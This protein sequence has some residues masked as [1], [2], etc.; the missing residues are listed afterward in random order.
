MHAE[1][2]GASSAFVELVDEDGLSVGSLDKLLA[3]RDPGHLHRAFSVVLHDER[4]RV[5]LQRRADEKYHFA[6][7]WSNSC[8]GH[9]PPGSALQSAAR[10]RTFAELGVDVPLHL[11]GSFVYRATDEDSGLVEH[12]LDSVLV[13]Q[14]P[15]DTVPLLDPSEVSATRWV[16]LAALV[17]E[18]T[19]DPRAFTPWLPQV[20]ALLPARPDGTHA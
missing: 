1:Q 15:A 6:G 7:R 11:V 20:L 5:L 10:D 17:V 13:G 16:G 2:R 4:G 18:L 12:E 8:C 3:H 19:A 9:P 14:L